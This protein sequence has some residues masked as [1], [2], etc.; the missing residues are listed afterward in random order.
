MPNQAHQTPEAPQQQPVKISVIIPV[1][2][3]GEKIQRCLETV[4]AQTIRPVEII[5]V[6]GYS[7]DDT[8]QKASEFP[9]TLCYEDYRT[10]AGAN[11]VGIESASGDYIAFTD[12]DCIPDACWLENLVKEFSDDIVGVGGGIVSSGDHFWEKTINHAFGTYL[13]SANSI[14][15]RF[16]NEKKIVNSISGCNC[17]YRRDDLKRINGF[18][19]KLATAEDTELNSRLSKIGKLLYTPDA[20]V[21]HNHKRGIK[22]FAKRMF[23][24]GHGRAKSRLWDVQVTPP[25]LAPVLLASIL[26]TPGIFVAVVSAYAVLLVIEG[27]RCS[28]K[29]GDIKYLLSVP[30]ALLI[31]HVYY[32]TGF[33]KGILQ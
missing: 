13:G 14:Q 5:V 22:A 1:K 15:G 18:D 24:Y 17:I 4:S 20:I 8:V 16:F 6:D 27:I 19:V 3:E 25:I 28:S 9:I 12:A 33:W 23:Q 31:E 10:R 2:N 29:E 26:I 11:Q 7:T 30:F 32:T 21:Y